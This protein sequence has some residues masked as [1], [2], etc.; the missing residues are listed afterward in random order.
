MRFSNLT[1]MC[2]LYVS[3]G[4]AAVVGSAL[5]SLVDTVETYNEA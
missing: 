1:V 3:D 5:R 2:K 4:C